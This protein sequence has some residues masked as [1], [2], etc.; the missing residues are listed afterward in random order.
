MKL[1]SKHIETILVLLFFL[2]L[3]FEKRH[4]FF[5]LGFQFA[6]FSA[7]AFYVSD[8][9][10]LALLGFA[11]VQRGFIA[12]LAKNRIFLILL[13]FLAFEA[14]I[15]PHGTFTTFSNVKWLEMSLIFGYFAI[16]QVSYATIL[17][18]ILVSGLFEAIIAIVQ[19]L[20]QGSLGLD[21]L[22]ETHLS[23]AVPGIAKLNTAVG[24]L[25]RPYGTFAHPNQLAA[26]LVVACATAAT[27]IILEKRQFLRMFYMVALI[28][29]VFAETIS[30]SR[31]GWLSTAIVLGLLV[32]VPHETIKKFGSLKRVALT[33]VT[34]VVFTLIIASPY[35]G[36]RITVT[37]ASTM[38][39]LYYD[40]AG[41]TTFAKN[42]ILGAGLG[43][44]LP[45]AARVEHFT[46]LWQL[47][48]PHNYFID[49]A[50]ET[51][52]VGLGVIIYI[53]GRLLIDLYKRLKMG[54][55]EQQIFKAMLFACLIGILILMQFDHYFYTLQQTQ[56]FLWAFLGI[57]YRAVYH[58]TRAYS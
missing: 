47:Q 38:S 4:I 25:V 36:P 7:I 32:L 17:N 9:A 53:F 35:I 34:A 19:F 12:K 24:T 55:S 44:L 40:Q 46:Q 20:K 54:E 33:I 43:Q 52:V 21:L 23:S 49:V 18:S 28:L 11:F 57:I 29:L 5:N 58:E 8:A 51:G 14:I 15:S 2:V 22:G 41:L 3:P 6:D 45:A 48:P 16:S 27:L 31:A 26:F 1:T 39:R 13:L 56:L 42:P 37:D 10:A 50:C 30:F